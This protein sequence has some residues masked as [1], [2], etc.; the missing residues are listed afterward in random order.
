MVSGRRTGRR[1]GNRGV[2]GG[3]TSRS[4]IRDRRFA[5]PSARSFKR[6]H[7]QCARETADGVRIRRRAR[8]Q[9]QHR[10]RTGRNARRLSS[11]RR[12]PGRTTTPD[13]PYPGPIR[14][15]RRGLAAQ[16]RD[17]RRPGGREAVDRSRVPHLVV[18]HTRFDEPERSRPRH[19]GDQRTVMAAHGATRRRAE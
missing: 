17:R 8:R 4:R 9:G 11:P 12:H 10:D 3:R 7:P 18:V 15:H 16:R 2:G 6:E 5:C 14:P 13:R 1:S 19:D